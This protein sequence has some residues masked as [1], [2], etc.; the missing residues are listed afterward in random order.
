[1]AI[2]SSSSGGLNLSQ[3]SSNVDIRLLKL[4]VLKNALCLAVFLA[5]GGYAIAY[6]QNPENKNKSNWIAAAII[7]GI[8]LLVFLPRLIIATYRFYAPS[9]QSPVFRNLMEDEEA[10]ATSLI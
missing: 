6:S 1:M 4:N 5:L 2:F 3:D 8:G 10:D 7:T 9:T